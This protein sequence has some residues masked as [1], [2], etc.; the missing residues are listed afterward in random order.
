MEKDKPEKKRVT[1]IIHEDDP[2]LH[3]VPFDTA[4]VPPPDLIK[5]YKNQYWVVHPT[6]GIAFW[7]IQKRHYPQ[8][9]GNKEITKRWLKHYPWAEVRFFASVFERIKPQDYC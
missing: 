9:N 7:T 8:C 5:H 4:V 1:D 3:Y 2:R 6:R